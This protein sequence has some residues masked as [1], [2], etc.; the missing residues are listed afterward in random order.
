ME[1]FIKHFFQNEIAIEKIRTLLFIKLSETLVF[2][3][4]NIFN[5]TVAKQGYNAYFQGYFFGSS[6]A[7]SYPVEA[8]K[9]PEW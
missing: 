1:I 8:S 5:K 9:I 4:C 2:K 3:F 6:C 7:L